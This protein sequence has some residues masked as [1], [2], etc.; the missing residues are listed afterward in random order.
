M[1]LSH[2]AQSPRASP[3]PQRNTQS[4]MSI[5][6]KCRKVRAGSEARGS[7]ENTPGRVNTGES[8]GGRRVQDPPSRHSAGR[9]ARTSGASSPGVRSC[10]GDSV[11]CRLQ[12]THRLC[13]S[14]FSP[15]NRRK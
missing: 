4:Q 5:V 2:P 1:L 6:A 11:H 15:V 14:P 13:G 7:L 10:L 3:S 9:R 8:G 12:Q